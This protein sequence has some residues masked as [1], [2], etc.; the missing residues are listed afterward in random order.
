[1]RCS[2]AAISTWRRA[3]TASRMTSRL[4]APLRRG[5]RLAQLLAEP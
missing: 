5:D 1:M 4:G 3:A 2:G